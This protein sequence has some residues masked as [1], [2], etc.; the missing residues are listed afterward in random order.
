MER[1]QDAEVKAAL[2]ASTEAAHA[3]GAFGSPTF[4]AGD[5]M[6]FGKERLRDVEDEVMRARG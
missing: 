6:W 2:L 5:E 3:R 1:S 4:F